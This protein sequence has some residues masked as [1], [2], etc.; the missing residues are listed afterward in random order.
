MSDTS[1][2]ASATVRPAEAAIDGLQAGLRFRLDRASVVAVPVPPDLRTAQDGS[3]PTH[4][5]AGR[6][7]EGPE[8]GAVGVWVCGDVAPH[9]AR[10]V[11]LGPIVA[12]N[13]TARAWSVWG[14]EVHPG[15]PLRTAARHASGSGLVAAVVSAC[16]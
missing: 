6:F 14:A 3:W 8:I 10:E 7:T 15:G 13:G 9:P 11:D 2:S 12:V 5:V 1:I 16:R 4:V